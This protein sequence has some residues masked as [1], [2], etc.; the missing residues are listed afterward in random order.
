MT[1]PD[2]TEFGDDAAEA[3]VV[4][5]LT[6]IDATDGDRWRDAASVSSARAWQA[7]EADLIDQ[8]ITVPQDDSEFDR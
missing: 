7:S 1:N 8:A 3:D 2:G 6:E 5:Q 4:E